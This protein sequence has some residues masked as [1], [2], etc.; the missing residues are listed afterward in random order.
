MQSDPAIKHCPE[1]NKLVSTWIIRKPKE[2]GW[3]YI[4]FYLLL[5]TN[6]LS[7]KENFIA[8]TLCS[9]FVFVPFNL[10]S[11]CDW[12][13]YACSFYVVLKDHDMGP[14]LNSKLGLGWQVRL[15]LAFSIDKT[16]SDV[17]FCWEW[18]D[19]CWLQCGWG[20]RNGV[21][22]VLFLTKEKLTQ[23]EQRLPS[24]IVQPRAFCSVCLT[25]AYSSS[26]KYE[27]SSASDNSSEK[28]KVHGITWC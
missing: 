4:L 15:E 20:W 21:S 14:D 11:S 27:P 10:H 12:V 28:A 5:N 16:A 24:S 7:S 3:M 23:G 18:C 1:N 17:L 22:V 19:V 8:V 9:L 2:F 26:C 13:Y 25:A 6:C